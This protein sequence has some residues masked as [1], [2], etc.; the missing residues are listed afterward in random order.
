MT[1]AEHITIIGAGTTRQAYIKRLSEEP[2]AEF[3]LEELP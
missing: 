2:A 3:R 1:N